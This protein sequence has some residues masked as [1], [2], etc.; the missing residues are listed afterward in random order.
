MASPSSSPEYLICLECETPCYD[1]EWS[2][3]GVGAVLCHACGN[4]EADQFISE[5]EFEALSE[6]VEG[7]KKR[8]R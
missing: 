2:G 1:F 6:G 5:E 7:Y 4:D 8:G 3:D